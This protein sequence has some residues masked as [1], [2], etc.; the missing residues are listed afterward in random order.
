VE[1]VQMQAQAVMNST[2]SIRLE[3]FAVDGG[4]PDFALDPE[5]PIKG[6]SGGWSV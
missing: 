6:I 4:H 2:L 1:Q 5:Y 3:V